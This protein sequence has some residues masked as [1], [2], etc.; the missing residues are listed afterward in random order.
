[1][2]ALNRAVIWLLTETPRHGESRR[3]T[4]E[5]AYRD[6]LAPIAAIRAGRPRGRRAVVVDFAQVS[7]HR[8]RGSRF[9]LR[10]ARGVHLAPGFA[11]CNSLRTPAAPPETFKKLAA[12]EIRAGDFPEGTSRNIARNPAPCWKPCTMAS[13]HERI[14]RTFPLRPAGMAAAAAARLPAALLRRGR[15]SDAAVMFPNLRCSSASAGAS[16][17]PPAA[18]ACRSLSSRSSPPSSP[19]PARSGET[20]TK[21]APPAAS[22]S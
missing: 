13:Q 20:N 5:A 10:N 14:P 8:R 2:I 4:R 9:A 6:A 1:V 7:F 11:A 22:I 3:R 18:S 15:G 17:A 19:W 21:A 12:L 16:A